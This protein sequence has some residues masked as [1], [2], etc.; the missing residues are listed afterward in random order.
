MKKLNWKKSEMNT[1][2][3]HDNYGNSLEGKSEEL[4]VTNRLL[5]EQADAVNHFP[6]LKSWDKVK[7]F[8]EVRDYFKD[9]EQD[10]LE[11]V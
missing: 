2:T 6:Y 10:D 5:L 8:E 7:Q 1:H 3:Y 11:P 9:I 4:W